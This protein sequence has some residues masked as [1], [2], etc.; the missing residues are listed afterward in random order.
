MSPQ[1]PVE[2]AGVESKQLIYMVVVDYFVL[3][4]I[5]SQWFG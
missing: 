5:S 4:I 2:V 1:Q 3:G